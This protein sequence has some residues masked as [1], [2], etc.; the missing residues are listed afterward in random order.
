MK[1]FHKLTS[2]LKKCLYPLK[3]KISNYS[4]VQRIINLQIYFSEKTKILN[5]SIKKK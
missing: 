2:S 4:D 3:R 1:T 5:I